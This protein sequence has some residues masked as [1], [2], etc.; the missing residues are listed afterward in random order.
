MVDRLPPADEADQDPDLG[1]FRAQ[2]LAALAA[3]D[4]EALRAHLYV[5]MGFGPDYQDAKPRN[6]AHFWGAEDPASPFWWK[7]ERALRW[8]GRFNPGR[9]FASPGLDLMWPEGLDPARHLV[10]AGPE[11]PLRAAPGPDAEVVAWLSY[12]LLALTPLPGQAETP[13][14]AGYDWHHAREH[15]VRPGFGLGEFH[16]VRRLADGRE[17][18]VFHRDAISPLEHQAY[19]SRIDDGRW[20][21]WVAFVAPGAERPAT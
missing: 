12:D 13:F 7:A 15:H 1:A 3:R 18:F 21:S 17:G 20:W 19:F 6:L 9:V 4:W 8:G 5:R 2:V 16:H 11:V 10:A 14:D